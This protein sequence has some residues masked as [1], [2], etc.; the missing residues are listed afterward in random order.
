MTNPTST[1][2]HAS[3]GKTEQ[4]MLMVQTGLILHYV[5]S[6]FDN[7][8]VYWSL[9]HLAEAADVAPNIPRDV[10]PQEA[11]RLFLRWALRPHDYNPSECPNWLANEN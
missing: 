11:A 6:Q 3:L 1:G 8:C 10:T 7:S 5:K 9:E 2:S 4:F